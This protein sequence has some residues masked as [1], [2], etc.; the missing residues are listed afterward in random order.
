MILPVL[1]TER[2]T[3]RQIEDGD[4]ERLQECGVL[5]CRLCVD[6]RFGTLLIYRVLQSEWA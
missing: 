3:L 1:E 2:L 5:R 6:G 4:A